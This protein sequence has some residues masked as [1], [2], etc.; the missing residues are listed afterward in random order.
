MK[1]E[2]IALLNPSEGVGSEIALQV[3]WFAPKS[4][5]R[6]KERA[7]RWNEWGPDRCEEEIEAMVE[8]MREEAAAR[9]LLMNALARPSVL[10]SMIRKAI[11]K[12]RSRPEGWERDSKKK[13]ATAAEVARK[14]TAVAVQQLSKPIVPALIDQIEIV[15]PHFNPVGFDRARETYYEWVPTLG[16]IAPHV[17]CVEAVLDDDPQEIE[18][19]T[20]LRGTRKRNLLWQKEAM[21]N[22]MLERTDRPFFCWLDHDLCFRNPYWLSQAIDKLQDPSCIAAQLFSQYVFLDARGRIL[23]RKQSAMMDLSMGGVGSGPP[24][25][26]WIARTDFLRSIGGLDVGNIVGGGDQGFFAGAAG[27]P[28]DY[29]F[30]PFMPPKFK[31]PE[32][33]YVF[34]VAAQRNGHSC[35]VI[36]GDAYHLFHGSRPNRQH[37]ERYKMLRDCDY[38]P[39]ADIKTDSSGLLTWAS[40]KPELHRGVREYFLARQEDDKTTLTD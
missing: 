27:G 19:S 26:A 33:D 28:T 20:V 31:K 37:E 6:C 16:D 5:A 17:K 13:V 7:E 23:Y 18:G 30:L 4:C 40:E 25:G 11:R 38:D 3:R 35:S 2:D 1:K 15:T 34:R 9:N 8:E 24:G 36:H 10:R 32:L 22:V 12:V 39:R 14:K 29:A 21:L